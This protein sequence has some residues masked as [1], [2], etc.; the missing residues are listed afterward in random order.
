MARI[1][2]GP[3]GKSA[4]APESE[5]HAVTDGTGIDRNPA[6]SPEGNLLYYQSERDGW[7]R[8][9]ARRIDQSSG[10]PWGSHFP[11]IIPIRRGCR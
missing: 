8:I 5:W 6:W 7:R 1:V 11:F 4:V 3:E 10:R 2:A 9:L